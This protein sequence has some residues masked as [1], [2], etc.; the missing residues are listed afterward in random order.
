MARMN[1][2]NYFQVS[3]DILQ[4][5]ISG[6]F[7]GLVIYWLD[8]RRAK[9]ERRLSDYRIASNWSTIRPKVSLRNFD[10][11]KANLSRCEFLGANLERA[12]LRGGSMYKTNFNGANLREADFRKSVVVGASF[13]DVIAYSANFSWAIIKRHP[14]HEYVSG[15]TKAILKDA[16]FIGTQLTMISMVAANLHNADFTKAIVE[17][18]DFSNSDLT[19]SK[20]LK[21]RK[22]ENCAWKNVKVGDAKNLPK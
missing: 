12:I 13:R 9:R 1:Q 21:V 17:N 15:F 20:W 8:E 6:V 4:A 22:V 14:D 7:V 16:K 5:V 2:V 18:C 3:I 11:T 19:G 10:L